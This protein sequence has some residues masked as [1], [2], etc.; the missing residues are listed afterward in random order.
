MSRRISLPSDL[1]FSSNSKAYATLDLPS[2]ANALHTG[3]FTLQEAA[4]QWIIS[5]ENPDKQNDDNT[6]RGG[7]PQ[8]RQAIQRSQPGASALPTP[9]NQSTPTLRECWGRL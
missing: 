1:T 4:A 6:A 8:V 3:D 2:I 9:I 7:L 5:D